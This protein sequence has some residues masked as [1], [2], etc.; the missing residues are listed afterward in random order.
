MAKAPDT[1]S[2]LPEADREGELPHPRSVYDLFGLDR[3]EETMVSALSS[4][5][6]HHGWM[7][8]GPKGVGKATLAYRLVRRILGA[9]D[10]GKGLESDPEDPVC[11]H[12]EALSH[13]DFLL[14][15]RPYDSARNRLKSEITVEETRKVASFFSQSASQDGWRVCLVDA[16]DEMNTN[17]ANALLKTLEEP[18][19]DC[20]LILV[21]HVPGR[22]PV[23]IRSR[24]RR[25]DVRAPQIEDTAN[26]LKNKHNVDRPVAEECAGLAHGAPGRALSLARHGGA[27]VKQSLDEILSGSGLKDRKALQTFVTRLTGKDSEQMR[28]L[29]FDFMMDYARDKARI[30]ARSSSHGQAAGWVQASDSLSRLVRDGDALHLDPRQTMFEAFDLIREAARKAAA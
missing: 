19:G 9:K 18:P 30:H 26:W 21:T 8:T 23:T 29:T 11:R 2:E 5:R 13:P 22:L 3:A 17:A 24:C 16:A 14:I 20:L 6:L 7:L 4:S 27:E 12:V 15:R 28:R 25:L 10:T 1:Q